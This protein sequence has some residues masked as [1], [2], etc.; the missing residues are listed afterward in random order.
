[1]PSESGERWYYQNVLLVRGTRV[2]LEKEP[3]FCK[4]GEMSWSASDG[5]F[6]RYAGSLVGS[7]RK[8]V[9]RIT[10]TECEYCGET[11]RRLRLPFARPA[12]NTVK[13]GSV[14]Y[15]RGVTQEQLVCPHR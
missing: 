10:L 15:V 1:M 3:V 11:A 4:A 14:T 5:G 8:M 9:A 2:R 7:G 12:R 13:L 6:P